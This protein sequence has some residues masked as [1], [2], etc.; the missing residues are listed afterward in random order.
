MSN[1]INNICER[2]ECIGAGS[3]GKSIT[4]YFKK[5]PAGNGLIAL[6]IGPSD[7]Y[8]TIEDFS[9]ELGK[10]AKEA[11]EINEYKVKSI[12]IPSKE[13]NES[14]VGY[15]EYVAINKK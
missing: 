12:K 2:Y 15:I 11:E 7:V 10:A 1:I 13:D 14:W 8:K 4:F 3:Y 5:D 6:F 9:T